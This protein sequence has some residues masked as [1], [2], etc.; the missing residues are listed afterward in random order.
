MKL[1]RSGAL[2]LACVAMVFGSLGTAAIAAS[3]VVVEVPFEFTAG[4]QNLPAGTYHFIEP[5]SGMNSLTIRNAASGES[6]MVPVITRLSRKNGDAPAV[7]FDKV[8]DMHYLSEVYIPG[9]DGFHLPGHPGKHEH[10]TVNASS[11]P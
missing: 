11:A 4:N 3:K 2:V 9:M 7:V 8:G 1:M 10:V 5:T 6:F